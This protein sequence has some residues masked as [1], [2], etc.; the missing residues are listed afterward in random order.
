M[1]VSVRVVLYQMCQY[2]IKDMLLS[3]EINVKS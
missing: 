1:N 3:P 2:S